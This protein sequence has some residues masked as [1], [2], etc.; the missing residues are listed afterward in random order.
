[1]K[2]VLVIGSGGRCHAICHALSR[3]ENVNEIFAAPG[4]LGI[5]SLATCV[6]IDVC[7]VD[8]LVKFAL[9]EKI[10]LT[11]VGPEASLAKGVVNEF[12]KNNLMIFGP[13]KEAAI[14]ESSK[15]FAKD[16]MKNYNIPTASYEVFRDF[17]SAYNYVKTHKL[18]TVIKYDGLAAGKG[19]VIANTLEEAHDALKDMLCDNKFGDSSVVIEEFLDGM[20]F[21]FM[22]LCN[23]E[24]AYPLIPS[25]DHKRAF[26]NDLGPNTGGMGAYTQLSFINEEDLDY[27]LNQIIIPTLKALKNEGREFCGVLYGGLIKTA[28]GIKVIEFNARFGD[29]ETEVVL[30]SLTSNICDVI[31]DIINEIEVNLTFTTKPTVGVVLAAKG[32]PGSY[33]KGGVIT[34]EDNDLGYIYHMG[35][36]ANQNGD[37]TINGGRVLMAVASADTLKDAQTKAYELVDKIHSDDLF[38]RHDIASKSLKG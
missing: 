4:N 2:K 25:Q 22:C 34:I 36:K 9:S 13:T 5:S 31:C 32:Y 14:I 1:M 23:G 27:S 33:S 6:D 20:E 8:N 19:V 12:K 21:S 30:Y 28:S 29:P 10:D 11:I 3:C 26:D 37:I 18:P 15:E 24:K 38:Y 35:T 7:D 16:L 17:D